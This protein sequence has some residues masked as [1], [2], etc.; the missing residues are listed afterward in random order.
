MLDTFLKVAYARDQ[1]TREQDEMV[2]ALQHLPLED[3]RKLA[4]GGPVPW[5]GVS[6]GNEFLDRFRGTP[7]F[8][9]A[10]VLEQE[11][12][13]AEMTDLQKREDR[14]LTEQ[15]DQS[16][17][18]QK[19]KIRL[20]KK[21][22]ELELAKQ[23]GEQ[24]GSTAPEDNAGGPPEALEP[25]PPAAGAP[26]AKMAARQKL[27]FADRVGRQLARQPLEKRALNL[28][29]LEQV[30]A[31][32]LGMARKN[33]QLAGMAA[34]AAGGALLGG[35]D[36]RL[37]GALSGAALG[38]MAAQATPSLG[39]LGAKATAATDAGAARVAKLRQG[40]KTPAASSPTAVTGTLGPPPA[41]EYARMPRLGTSPAVSANLQAPNVAAFQAPSTSQRI[42]QAWNARVSGAG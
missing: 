24:A 8:E 13:Q 20:K 4:D 17:Y 12:L 39:S 30:G 37:G 38:G 2:A 42:R 31:K 15:N 21:M 3:L 9:Q 5:D 1:R 28:G 19:D 6:S 22:L 36:H 16:L 18:A 33:P 26:G 11:E 41:A 29:A 34:G 23:H 14:R 35:P 7:L 25:V 27:A 32:A 40:L 10:M